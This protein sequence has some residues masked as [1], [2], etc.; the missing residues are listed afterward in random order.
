M[1]TALIPAYRKSAASGSRVY[2]SE[3]GLGISDAASISP[4]L[5]LMVNPFMAEKITV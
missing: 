4:D 5:P 1:L 3:N 2:V